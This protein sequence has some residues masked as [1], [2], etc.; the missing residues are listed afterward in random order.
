MYQV[1]LGNSLCSQS[2]LAAALQ[3]RTVKGG[4]QDC[5]PGKGERRSALQPFSAHSLEPVM[6]LYSSSW[7]WWLQPLPPW[8]ESGCFWLL[9]TRL[10]IVWFLCCQKIAALR[11]VPKVP[12]SCSPQSRVWHLAGQ[13]GKPLTG[14]LL[15]IPYKTLISPGI[16]FYL[17]PACSALMLW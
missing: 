4:V 10:L 9:Q 13:K 1:L 6:G 5:L 16:L 8:R 14:S 17:W 11:C 2:Q 7:N 15:K 3:S 12:A